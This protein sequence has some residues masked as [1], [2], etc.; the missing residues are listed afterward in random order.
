MTAIIGNL[1]EYFPSTVEDVGAWTYIF[2]DLCRSAI[3]EFLR[4]QPSRDDAIEFIAVI[5]NY[6]GF[7]KEY[8][9]PYWTKRT[10]RALF[11]NPDVLEKAS[12]LDE[13]FRNYPGG[14]RGAQAQE[15]IFRA[16]NVCRARYG[17][18]PLDIELWQ[19]AG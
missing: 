12:I 19:I 11:K 7:W 17:L 18:P 16:E 4:T 5:D 1:A 2:L 8:L 6:A 9:D 15:E 3:M 13:A 14:Y 10:V